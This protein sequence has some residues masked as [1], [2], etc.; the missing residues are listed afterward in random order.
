MYINL[1]IKAFFAVPQYNLRSSKSAILLRH[2]VD[3]LLFLFLIRCSVVPLWGFNHIMVDKIVALHIFLSNLNER[4]ALCT[5]APHT[6][7]YTL[8]SS[9]CC[10]FVLYEKTGFFYH[11]TKSLQQGKG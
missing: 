8:F 3:S 4:I 11:N 10:R 2:P 1:F 7:K 6:C 9:S 5:L